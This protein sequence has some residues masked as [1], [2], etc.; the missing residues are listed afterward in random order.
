MDAQIKITN[1]SSPQHIDIKGDT[2]EILPLGSG[3]E[4]GRSCIILN[5]QSKTIMLDC[6]IHPAYSGINSLP[7]FDEIDPS[8]VD[9]LLITH[10][11][12]DHCGALPY[13]LE[14]TTFNGDCYMTHPSKAIYKYILA[15]YV[16]VSHANIEGALFEEKDLKKSLDKIK[17]IDYHQEIN[18]KGIK[19]T[20]YNAGHVLGAAMFLIEISGIKILYTGDF[21]R[22]D[23]RHL[24]PAEVPEQDI[25]ILIVESTYGIHQ[26]EKR[27]EREHNFT[28]YVDEI[29]SRGGKCLLPVF[30]IGRAQEL[31]LILDEYWETDE[32]FKQIKIYYASSLAT[33]S[34]D[35]FKTYINMA[36]EYIKNKYSSE[37]KNPFDF[38]HIDCV[39]TIENLDESKPVV[40]FASPGMLQSGLSRTLFDRW[41]TDP[42]NG[43]VITGYCVD[44]TI[45]KHLLGEPSEIELTDGKKV[46]MNMTVKNV[47]FS[48]HSDFTHTNEFILKLQPKN[49]I[50][51]HGEGKE[52]ERLRNEYERL[53]VDNNIYK[54]FMPR[55]F[56]PKNCQRLIFNFKIQKDGFIVG[57]MCQK[58]LNNFDKDKMILD[59]LVNDTHYISNLENDKMEIENEK[60]EK[61]DKSDNNENNENNENVFIENNYIEVS[62][63]LLNESNIFLE[64]G[65]ISKFCEIQ[66]MKLKQ[67]LKIK[68]T[69]CFEILFNILK[70]YFKIIDELK[71]NE[72][73]ICNEVKMYVQKEFIVLEWYSNGYNDFLANSLAMTINQLETSP[74]NNVFKHYKNDNELCDYKKEKLITF[75]K[76]KY[77]NVNE[78]NE[79]KNVVIVENDNICEIVNFLKKEVKCDNEEFREKIIADLQFFE[80]L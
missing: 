23:D 30:S 47:T 51:V 75:L 28:K 39:K 77:S 14:K 49:I 70:D 66:P 17:L 36:G 5:F 72:Y 55:V 34:I 31:L 38:E 6:G 41:C 35:I 37:G 48:A 26:H 7:Y 2:L 78:N 25:H 11:H 1:L 62:G 44:G 56:N 63:I 46:P 45:G 54:K 40:V 19:F 29:V 60:K 42:K 16:K 22:E 32:K 57:D 58:I 80:E 9:L 3:S 52:M 73:L 21:S 12:L 8:T 15:D 4:V 50:L 65:E 74:N 10:F 71:E 13:F 24:K 59:S 18:T 68:Y 33:N 20:A 76:T 64:K 69:L 27:L 67:I 53:K 79:N 43:V 61:S